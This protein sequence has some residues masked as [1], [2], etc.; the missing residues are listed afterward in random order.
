M[1]LGIF[2]LAATLSCAPA[3]TDASAPPAAATA[4]RFTVDDLDHLPIPDGVESCMEIHGHATMPLPK[5]MD[6]NV[7]AQKHQ[8][9]TARNGAQ[10]QTLS[11]DEFTEAYYEK[12][13]FN[14]AA[15]STLV[16]WRFR[17][18]DGTYHWWGSITPYCDRYVECCEYP[19]D[20]EINT[21]EGS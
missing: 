19:Y 7:H 9:A 11:C 17:F 5:M 16:G 13:Y 12:D 18:C 10:R 8:A 14:N 3:D 20:N 2:L 4:P 6:R 1:G 21:C 15:H